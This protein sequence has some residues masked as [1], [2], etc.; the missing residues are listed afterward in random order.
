MA[1]RLQNVK[2][3]N[4]PRTGTSAEK[5][6]Y[7][8]EKRVHEKSV[9]ASQCFALRV[10]NRA[11]CHADSTR[12]WSVPVREVRRGYGRGERYAAVVIV[13]RRAVC[14]LPRCERS[15][16][17]EQVGR[18]VE[19]AECCRR[20]SAQIR[21][22]YPWFATNGWWRIRSPMERALRGRSASNAR[23]C[24]TQQQVGCGKR[25]RKTGEGGGEREY[26]ED[27]TRKR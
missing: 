23:V 4:V 1:E 7:K 17:S 26:R 13:V 12:M 11:C 24:C 25:Q 15:W 3:E 16:S 27:A 14:E 18:V 21:H 8:S 2:E 9:P 22:I 20:P 19:C 5:G 10:G 6:R